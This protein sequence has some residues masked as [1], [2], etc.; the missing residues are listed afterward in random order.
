MGGKPEVVRI[1]YGV[2]SLQ[3][4][5]SVVTLAEPRGTTVIPVQ[6]IAS[7]SIP[8]YLNARMEM[9]IVTVDGQVHKFP[10]AWQRKKVSAFRDAVLAAQQSG[11]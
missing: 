2:K 5:G 8:S 1:S 7:I 4:D 6:R 10:A 3:F 9:T 11:Q